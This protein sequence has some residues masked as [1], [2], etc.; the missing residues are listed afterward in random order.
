MKF[1]Q[2]LEEALR[3]MNWGQRELGE[4]SGVDGPTINALIRRHSDRSNY[5]DQLIG[6]FPSGRI[7][8]NW[9]RNGTGAMTPSS[10]ESE[11]GINVDETTTQPPDNDTITIPQFKTGGAMGDGVAL[12]DQPGIIKSWTVSQEWARQNVR[13][14]T[15]LANLCIVTGFGDSMR[16]MFNPGDPLICDRGV[17]TVEFDG[18]YF[19]RV[20][21]EGF[22]KR[23]QRVPGEGIL[24][25]SENTA[26][27]TWTIKPTMDFEVFGRILKAWVSEDF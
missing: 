8:H 7:S 11:V 14:C 6:A 21:N 23:L 12:R 18:V 22:I 3:E 25:L 19:F 2:R 24:A 13:G 4:R 9:L 10:A 20:E 1:G 27:R 15:S 17:R 16:G 5:K 26:Y